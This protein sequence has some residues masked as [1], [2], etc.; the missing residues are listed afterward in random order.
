MEAIPAPAQS[1]LANMVP[2]PS[3]VEKNATA[4][5]AGQRTP[6]RATG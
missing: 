1:W 4:A 6:T 2:R 5:S 3:V